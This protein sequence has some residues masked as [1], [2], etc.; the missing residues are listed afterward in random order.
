MTTQEDHVIIH[1][2]RNISFILPIILIIFSL[3]CTFPFIGKTTPT[4]PSSTSIPATTIPPT[5]TP[6]PLSPELVESDPSQSVEVPLEGPI[7]L[8]F[9]QPMDRS[10]V[11]AALRSQLQQQLTFSWT[12]DSTVVVYLSKSLTPETELA[13]NLGSDVHSAQGT[14]LMQPISLSYR[15]AG[16]LRLSQ[17]LPE[18]NSVDIDP[19]SAIVTAFNRPIVPLGS[20][21]ASL[22]SAFTLEPVAQ[23][24]GEWLNTSTFIFYPEPSLEGGESYTVHLNSDLKSTTGGPL[25]DIQTWSF[26]T[27]LPRLLSMAPETE[28]PWPLDAGVILT[29]NQ[30]MDPASVEANFSLVDSSGNPVLGKGSWDEDSTIFTFTPTS[31]LPRNASFTVRLN[32]QAQARGGTPLGDSLNSTIVTVPNLAVGNTDPAPG[33]SVDPY[34]NVVLHF[35]APILDKNVQNYVSIEP[36]VSDFQVWA[37]G[38]ALRLSGFFIPHTSYAVKISPSL[39][40]IWGGGLGEE[41]Q[42]NFSIN[43]WPP[44]LRVSSVAGAIFITPQDSSLNV[45]AVNVSSVPLSVGSAPL[46]DFLALLGPQGYELEEAYHSPDQRTWSQALDLEPDKVQFTELYL[47]QDRSTL[48]PG[49]YVMRLETSQSDELSQANVSAGPYLIV[50][51]NLQVTFKISPSDA[52]IWAVDLRNN[53]P[54]AHKP[55]TI[56]DF[57]GSVLASGQTDVDGIFTSDYSPREDGYRPAFAVIGQTG[58]DDFGMGLSYWSTGIEPWDFDIPSSSDPPG[59]RVYFYTDRPIYRPGQTVYFRAVVRKANNG[60]YSPPDIASLPVTITGNEG[61]VIVDLDLPL[62]S[63]GAVHGEFDLSASAQPGFYQ[64]STSQ[65]RQATLGFQVANYRKPEINLQA[66]FSD[67]EVQAG[68]EATVKVNARYFF[69][70]PVS[71][72][73]VHWVLYSKSSYFHLSGYRVGLE[74]TGWLESY[75]YPEFSGSL[76]KPVAEGDAQTGIDGTLSLDFPTELGDSRQLLTLEATITDESGLPVSARASAT[77]NPDEFFIGLRPDAWIG[78][79]GEKIGIDVQVADWA[80]SNLGKP[81][82]SVRNLRAEFKKVIWERE[83]P[84]L[85]N[86]AGLPQFTPEYTEIGSTD[87]TTS[88]EGNARIAFT[89][90]EPGTYLL[91]VYNALGSDPSKGARTQFLLWVGGTGEAIWP[92]L[93]NSRLR[94]TSDKDTYHVAETTQPAES[95]EPEEEARIFIPNPFGDQVQ[96]LFTIERGV[97]MQ[98]R[99]LTIP[100]GGYEL[101]LPV[102]AEYAPNVFLSVTLLGKDAQGKPD[103]RQG[104]LEL[105]VEPVEQT[106]NVELTSQPE[107]AAPGDEIN[108]EVIVTDWTGKPVQGEF[109]LAVVDLA[110]LALADANSDDIITAFYGVQPDSVH[111]GLSL[112]AYTRRLLHL[113]LG[114]GGGGGEETPIVA[115]EKFPDTAYW[116]AEVVTGA[117]GR[118]QV[119]VTLPDTLTTWHVESRGLTLDTRVGQAQSQVI[120]TKELLVR[121]VTPRFLVMG[122]HA[123][124][125]A[126]VQNNSSSDMQVEASLQSSGFALDDPASLSQQVNIPAQGRARLEWWGTVQDVESVDPIFTIQGKGEASGML[127]Q[128]ASRPSWGILPVLRYLSP[129]TFRTSGTLDTAGEIKELVSLPRSFEVI[130]GNLN[131]ELSP[132]LAGAMLQALESLEHS[133]CESTEQ[134]LSSF[135][136]NLETYRTM[137]EFGIEDPTLKARLDRT[138]NEG[139]NLLLARQNYDGGWSWWQNPSLEGS[140]SESYITSYVLFG[141]SRAQAAGI[142]INQE[143]IQRAVDYLKEGSPSPPMGDATL[144]HFLAFLMDRSPV[145]GGGGS[146]WPVETWEFDRLVFRQFAL[147][148]QGAADLDTVMALYREREMLSLWA[149]A[150]L[151]YTLEHLSPSSPEAITLL[152]GVQTSSIRSATGAHWEFSQDKAGWLATMNNMHTALSNSAIVLYVLAQRDPGSPL[153]TDSVRYLMASRDAEGAWGSTYTTAWTLMSLDQVM[154]ATSELGGDFSYHATLNQNT[155]AEGQVGGEKAL[156]PVIADVAAQRLYPDYPNALSIE[157]DAGQGRLYYTASLQV[158]SPVEGAPALSQ[159]LGIERAYYLHGE[160]CSKDDCTPVQSAKVGQK[161]DVRLTLSLPNDVYYLAV[162]DAIPAGAEILDTGLKTTQIGESVEPEAVQLYDPR[163]PFHDGWGWWLFN[164][165]QIFDDHILWTADYLPAGSYQLKYTLTLYQPGQYRVLPARSWQLYFPEVQANTAGMTFEITP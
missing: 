3:A 55:V 141:L 114:L 24:R 69:D 130:G 85:G 7:T 89:P 42:Y 19:S 61:Q 95:T 126:I 30:P 155:I 26:T 35:T 137:Q 31:L 84:P 133:Q 139:L 44:D 39:S 118:A 116:N 47:T 152:S 150:L 109:S 119:S 151:A 65:D 23:G 153:V 33:G 91:D 140:V 57:D 154:Q 32:G 77:V 146:D 97:V 159:G 17:I 115:R 41:Y 46:N 21:P 104:L 51:S 82:G 87:F 158:E 72:A 100:A 92:S 135:L 132:S 16:Y 111:T 64:I 60:R 43:P 56:Y 165:S 88:Q 81:L 138:L 120:T 58:E 66:S 131:V 18:K 145:A 79:A 156:T 63:Y 4:S 70:A 9:N 34:S 78:R 22:P 11:E 53:S 2:R 148:A 124:L 98:H 122:D 50:S 125:A 54:A 102:T 20:D 15:A 36:S 8:F 134:T 142:T 6:P 121:P 25:Q 105:S 12:D 37:D 67:E 71:E 127:Y 110:A 40:D 106:L 163:R 38:Y 75:L 101:S 94:L 73:A 93:P 112:A 13:I 103:F 74:D 62:T 128:D 157:R 68:S 108:F 28:I 147:D 162:T 90:P 29:F 113:P 14:P 117:D 49:L 86:A 143:V 99:I 52:L 149:Q 48:A 59:L 144:F 129:H 80:S 161:V 45:Q 1:W 27:A 76:G 96:A 83:D 10:S 123:Q 5:P 164:P 160:S 136:P 107:K